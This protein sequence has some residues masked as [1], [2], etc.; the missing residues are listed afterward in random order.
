[1][2]NAPRLSAR[3]PPVAAGVR[4]AWSQ[5]PR[6]AHDWLAGVLGSPVVESHAQLGGFSP[7]AAVR[8]VCADGSRAFAKAVSSS[9]NTDSVRMYR[10]EGRIVQALP[11]HPSV[12]RLLGS[13]DDGTWVVL[14][15]EDVEGRQPRLPWQADELALV[16]DTVTELG[17]LLDPNPV[18]D[19][20]SLGAELAAMA[21]LWQEL[22]A[23]PPT[24]LD[25]WLR[26]HL[27]D[28]VAWAQR[29]AP[30]GTALVHLDIRADNLLLTPSGDVCVLDWANAGTGPG[31][32]DPTYLML[33][34]QAHGGHDV[35]RL[36]AE[37]PLTRTV[38]REDITWAVL[39]AA[40][41]FEQRC[42]QPA[43]PGL[44]TIRPFQRAYA[45]TATTWLRARLPTWP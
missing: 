14:A 8:L 20:Y 45:H 39:A 1:M 27:P 34:V 38:D 11:A 19:C 22:A 32:L 29:P 33:E 40:A 9:M 36:L 3:V 7:G 42:R 5:V 2:S 24:D 17:E 23:D 31:W 30:D 18:P 12:P 16:L 6:P 4:A 41:M 35:E 21:N 44:P 43:P 13:Y 25:P 10:Y 28:L 26:Q 37:H 15:F